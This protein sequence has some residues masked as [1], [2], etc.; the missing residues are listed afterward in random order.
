MKNYLKKLPRKLRDLIY[1]ARD[2]AKKEGLH[3]CLVGGFVRDLILGINPSTTLRIDL[4]L[5][6]EGNA[7]R[8]AR[9]YAR[10]LSGRTVCHSRFQSATVIVSN[11][12]KIDI[13]TARRESYPKPGALP[14][15]FAATINE[16][17]KRRD[18]TINTLALD[19]TNDNFG[20][21]LD[22]YNGMVDLG[23]RKIRILHNQSFIDDPTR[24]LRAVR[25]EQRLNFRIEPHTLRLLKKAAFDNLLELVS[26]HRLRDEIILLLKEA[27]PLMYIKRIENIVGF[28]FFYPGL[29]LKRGDWYFLR[30]VDNEIQWFNENFPLI[31]LSFSWLLYWAA[32]LE[33]LNI[34]ILGKHLYRFGLRKEEISAILSYRQIRLPLFKRLNKEKLAPS[35]VFRLLKPL[36]LE[37]I[38]LVKA[39]Y[40]SVNLSNHI[41]KFLR[42]YHGRVPFIDGHIL[43]KLGFKPG[44]CY[45]QILNQLLYRQLD[46]KIK[47]KEEAIVWLKKR[48]A[49][50]AKRKVEVKSVETLI[51]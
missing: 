43:L 46:D 41:E 11:K 48:K 7:I 51:L 47:S 39:R 40:R 44:P 20:N 8:F 23:K 35:L 31:G 33:P 19:L 4:D 14:Q 16:D 1:L 28:D 34:R 10:R 26:C 25:F 24:I 17:L 13:A 30:C 45:K 9:E 27:R 18:F 37:T 50:S 2:V 5:V 21:L 3:A 32:I 49:K 36:S 22:F 42:Y 29:K 12:V 38:L 15:V 6:I